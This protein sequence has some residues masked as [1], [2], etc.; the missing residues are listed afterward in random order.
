MNR[1][2]ML[3]LLCPHAL[4]A[5]YLIDFEGGSGPGGEVPPHWR[6]VEVPGNRWECSDENA[7]SG[8][9]S[10]HHAHDNAENGCDYLVIIHDPLVSGDS[11]SISFRVR[12]SYPPSAA[13]NWQLAFLADL[14]S[15]EGV[16]TRI[17]GGWV[18]GVN[19]DGPDDQVRL[20]QV[21]GGAT[22][23]LCTSTINY[24]EEVGTDAAPLF[25]LTCKPDGTLTLYYTIDPGEG[26]PEKIAFCPAGSIP[27]GRSLVVRYQYSA[28]QDMKLWLDDLRLDGHFARDTSPPVIVNW[29]IPGSDRTGLALSECI[30][31]PDISHF[32]L[33]F[34]KISGGPNPGSGAT[35]DS[36]EL[37]D[38]SLL[39][40]FRE[41]I[42]NRVPLELSVKGLSDL[43]GNRMADTLIRLMRNEPVW[44]DVVFNEVMHDPEPPVGLSG[45]EYLE[46]LNRSDFSLD[47]EGWKLAVGDHIHILTGED[48][49]SVA[50]LDPGLGPGY[51]RVIRNIQLPNAGATLALYSREGT[52]VHAARYQVPYDGPEWKKEGGWSLES[53]DPDLVCNTSMLWQYSTD[54]SGGTPGRL[55]SVDSELE[56]L[57]VPRFL[58]CG[59]GDPGIIHLQ[60]SETVRFYPGDAHD[61]ILYPGNLNADSVVAEWPLSEGF[62][63]YFPVDLA[64][65]ADFT[66]Q[67]P[68]PADC[69]GNR[70]GDLVFRAGR[71]SV[72][73]Y[74]SVLVSEIMYD[75]A[76]GAPEFIELYNPGPRFMDLKELA[77]DVVPEGEAPEKFEALSLHSRIFTPGTYL[78]VARNI[79]HL[80]DAYGLEV[81]GCWLE[82]GEL[83]QLPNSGGMV[84]LADRAGN[85]VDAAVYG[86]W[87]HMDMIDD[88]RGISLERV[89]W[90]RPGT[91]PGNWHSAASLEGYSTP[92]RPNSQSAPENGGS[93][94]LELEPKVFSPDNDGYNDMLVISLNPG[95]QGHVIRL[96]IT[97]LSGNRVRTLAN[98]HITG[99]V[100]SYTWDGKC[101][102]GVMAREGIYV[103][104]AS[105]YQPVSGYRWNRKAATA[106]LEPK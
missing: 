104:H 5:Q 80:Q 64:G 14:S 24:Q 10:L 4:L 94:L 57:Q 95:G 98:H 67:V 3:L 66:I 59:F 56:D 20:W 87:M 51:Y 69:Q 9:S 82:V 106:I 29:W 84:Y 38:T 81:S 8:S 39:L 60:Y 36:L 50:G 2:W 52:L 49:L 47:L 71:T 62:S 33:G 13:N 48:H 75:P 22:R 19:F 42:P 93:G 83:E 28:A 40:F 55:N 7:I 43:D 97:D 74:G 100:A 88:S 90:D 34:G 91:D 1:I 99:P 46:L 12:Y 25:S 103:V 77:L 23:E 45:E 65:L 76:E 16:E 105:G 92:G 53:P 101:D 72:P 68:G 70:A 21:E 63:C 44:G 30:Q 85:T 35:P 73:F 17:T 15:G 102:N 96:W 79:A 11:F 31:W 6:V 27:G 78:V 54:R 26:P 41:P 61:V 86:D 89:A 18:I 32:S 58:Y 37:K